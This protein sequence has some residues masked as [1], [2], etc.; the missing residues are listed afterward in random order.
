MF[1]TVEL[2]RR[3]LSNKQNNIDWSEY[4]STLKALGASNKRINSRDEFNVLIVRLSSPANINSIVT[5]QFSNLLNKITF[6]SL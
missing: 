6:F 3:R 2:R 1:N 4:D 5:T